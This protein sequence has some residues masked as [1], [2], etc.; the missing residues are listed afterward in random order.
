M[1][2]YR[3]EALFIRYVPVNSCTGWQV[4]TDCATLTTA[5]QTQQIQEYIVGRP[6]RIVTHEIV[7]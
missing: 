7:I 1:I 2:V 6:A 5:L 3:V 4:W